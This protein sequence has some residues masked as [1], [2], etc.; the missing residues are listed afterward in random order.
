MRILSIGAHPDDIEFGC[1]GTLFKHIA[2]GDKV[3]TLILSNGEGTTGTPHERCREAEVASV[4]MGV[5]SIRFGRI[6][7]REMSC[8]RYEYGDIV[9][10]AVNDIKPDR[11]Y[12]HNKSDRHQNHEVAAT[13]SLVGGRSVRQILS[14]QLPSTTADFQPT[15]YVDVLE[16]VERKLGCLAIFRTQAHKEYM[17]EWWHKSI[18]ARHA[19]DAHMLDGMCEAFY[20]E[21]MVW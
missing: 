16:Y 19:V 4:F 6:P 13:C 3:H 1:G 9:S 5:T 7:G 12:C 15:F 20:V 2:N 17:Q 11:I 21:R 8:M 14:F 18:M 10:R